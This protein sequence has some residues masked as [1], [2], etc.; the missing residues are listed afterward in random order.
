MC[1]E[2]L[3]SEDNFFGM[4][5]ER[6]GSAPIAG[7]QGLDGLISRFAALDGLPLPHEVVSRNL[8]VDTIG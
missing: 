6:F 8:V 7:Q 4:G 5:P 2:R 1:V 3:Q